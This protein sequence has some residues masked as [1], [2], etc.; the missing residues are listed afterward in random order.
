MLKNRLF[1]TTLLERTAVRK[2]LLLIPIIIICVSVC[3][4][5]SETQK[6]SALRAII[7]SKFEEGE[8]TGDFPGEAQLFYERY[9]P[10][11]EEIDIPH[12]PPTAHFYM[13]K[14]NGVGLLIT[15]SG[16]TA[17]GLSLVTL[18]SSEV[19]DC[20]DAYIVSVGCAGGSVGYSTIGDVVLITTACDYDLDHQVD[21]RDMGNT[22]SAVT[23]FSDEAY[24]EYSCKFLNADLCERVYEMIKDC[25]LRTTELTQSVLQRNYPRWEGA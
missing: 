1:H 20:S 8:I 9:C 4:S 2:R 11:C 10:D 17:A 12:M 24:A 21:S 13:N 7:V 3:S 18:L 14:E 16:K 5:C 23:W 25:S 15:G 19:C 22:D 6:R